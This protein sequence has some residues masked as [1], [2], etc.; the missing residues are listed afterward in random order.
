MAE[1][2]GTLQGAWLLGGVAVAIWHEW[3]RARTAHPG[4]A[5][6]RSKIGEELVY[7]WFGGIVVMGFLQYLLGNAP[8]PDPADYSH[9]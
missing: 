4:E 8:P 1:I 6:Y 5:A 3:W 2:L 9:D 7:I